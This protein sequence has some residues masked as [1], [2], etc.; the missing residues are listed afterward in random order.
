MDSKLYH[1]FKHT[2]KQIPF[3]KTTKKTGVEGVVKHDDL[4]KLIESKL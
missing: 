4:K 2:R 1:I 3:W